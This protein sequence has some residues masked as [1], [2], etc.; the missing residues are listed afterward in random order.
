MIV[1]VWRSK[2][3]V[4]WCAQIIDRGSLALFIRRP[5]R[6]DAERDIERAASDIRATKGVFSLRGA[7]D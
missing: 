4:G 2:Y 1:D 5:T 6:S 3:G 7:R